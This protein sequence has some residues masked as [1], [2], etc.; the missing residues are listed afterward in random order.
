MD[1]FRTEISRGLGAAPKLLHV[2]RRRKGEV[3]AA[4]VFDRCKHTP[5]ERRGGSERRR[6][7]SACRH[8]TYFS[9]LFL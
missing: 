7:R 6:E 5:V 8:A 2:R 1:I 9:T 3:P 4:R